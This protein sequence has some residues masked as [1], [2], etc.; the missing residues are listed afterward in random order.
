MPPILLSQRNGVDD[1]Q[2]DEGVGNGEKEADEWRCALH[3][4]ESLIGR[5][6]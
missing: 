6:M 5:S 1:D 3:S 4:L 2:E